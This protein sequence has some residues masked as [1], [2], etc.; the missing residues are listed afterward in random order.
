MYLPLADNAVVEYC[1]FQ[2]QDSQNPAQ[3]HTN[4]IYC[5]QITNST[6]RVN[7]LYDIQV[8]GL[9]FNDSDNSNILIYGNLFYQG[10]VPLNTGRAI[11]FTGPGNSGI[12]VYSNTFVD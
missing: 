11:Q 10:S 1:S 2:G 12:F 8:E 5:W 7:K 9:F 4:V 6:F 3:F